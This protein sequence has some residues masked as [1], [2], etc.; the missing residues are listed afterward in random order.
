M[1]QAMIVIPITMPLVQSMESVSFSLC[2]LNVIILQAP[3]PV[4]N[5]RLLAPLPDFG[6]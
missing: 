4:K 1:I 5:F 2:T 3:S 6:S